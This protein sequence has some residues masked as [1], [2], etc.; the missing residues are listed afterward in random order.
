VSLNGDSIGESCT[1]ELLF[2][3]VELGARE[4]LMRARGVCVDGGHRD[5]DLIADRFS[6]RRNDGLLRVLLFCLPFF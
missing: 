3:E 6:F 2:I 5:D 1:T 4:R